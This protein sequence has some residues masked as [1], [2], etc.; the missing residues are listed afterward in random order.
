MENDRVVLTGSE[1]VR[2]LIVAALIVAGVGLFFYF[3]KSTRPVVSPTVEE[4]V[5]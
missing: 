4:T 2:W 5:R 3:A 1:M